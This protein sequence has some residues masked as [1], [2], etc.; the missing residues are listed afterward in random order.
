MTFGY[1]SALLAFALLCATEASAQQAAADARGE[2]GERTCSKIS[3]SITED[4][5]G[6]YYLRFATV[7]PEDT[8]RI[9][10][11]AGSTGRLK[12]KERSLA[13]VHYGMRIDARGVPLGPDVALAIAA[14]SGVVEP[15]PA[16]LS[17]LSLR[18]AHAGGFTPALKIDPRLYEK[19]GDVF[20]NIGGPGGAKFG[21]EEIPQA[22]MTAEAEA[23]SRGPA[24]LEL[25]QNGKVIMNV[26][27][28]LAGYMPTR[29]A[30]LAYAK[31]EIPLLVAGKCS[32]H[33]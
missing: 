7:S 9:R 28:T 30:A 15:L 20:G 4:G 32:T 19:F 3:F 8:M 12:A 27:F 24:T 26:D 13:M 2:H 16:P 5:P 21:M 6:Q 29:E 10:Y 14:T 33:Y 25:L 23:I 1:R 31:A 18:I 22:T 11:P 17:S